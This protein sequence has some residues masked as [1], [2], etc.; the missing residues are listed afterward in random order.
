MDVLLD[1]QLLAS[2]RGD[3]RRAGKPSTASVA[4]DDARAS[5]ESGVAFIGVCCLPTRLDA[6]FSLPC[7]VVAMS[8]RGE[9]RAKLFLPCGV[10][11]S[12]L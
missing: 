6:L 3:S 9:L 7:G 11:L 12:R 4:A 2:S 8:R 5:L 10:L 1:G